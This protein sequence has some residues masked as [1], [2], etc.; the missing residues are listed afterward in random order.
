MFLRSLVVIALLSVG[1]GA[2]PP[3][4]WV[5]HFDAGMA[6]E[7]AP[8]LGNLL[9]VIPP[10]GKLLVG[11][12]N[13]AD[14]CLFQRTFGLDERPDPRIEFIV[15]GKPVSGW[16]RDR[17][18]VF[19]R[20]GKRCVALPPADAVPPE[21]AGD[22]VIA[23]KIAERDP[24]LV[25]V[26][27]DLAL[28]GG[29]VVLT[30]KHAFV[31]I[32]EVVLNAQR[33][34]TSGT[35][36]HRRMEALFGRP[37]VVIGVPDGRLALQHIDMF[38]SATPGGTLLLGDPRLAPATPDP[39]LER[40]G[41]FPE[42]LQQDYA[43]EY[44]DIA[45][46]LSRRGF[47]IRRLPILHSDDGMIMTWTNVVLRGRRVFVPSY[48]VGAAERRAYGAW[49]REGLVVTPVTTDAVIGLGGAV[50]C[51]TNS[52]WGKPDE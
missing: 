15:A 5:C 30:K 4:V 24:N 25:L 52:V 13:T 46:A 26:E 16:A 8:T 29:N 38:L 33:L 45:A 7:S 48:G 3:R 6:E 39:E 51:V 18:I 17:Y 42:R 34:E 47:G 19:E 49:R 10:R 41:R 22:L 2:D 14:A 50:R 40:Y 31:G 21:W 27:T 37:V 43:R 9:E 35:D 20:E 44:R 28:E 36:V 11:V 1:A 32:G 23:R 12:A